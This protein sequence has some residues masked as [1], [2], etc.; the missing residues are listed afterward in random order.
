M[1]GQGNRLGYGF[2]WDQALKGRHNRCLAPSG[3]G[4]LTT[5][6]PRALPWAGMSR[7]F[8]ADRAIFTMQVIENLIKLAKDLDAATKAGKE[9]GLT[10]DEKAFYD[11]LAA[12]DSAVTAGRILTVPPL[13]R[14]ESVAQVSN[15]LCRRFPNRRCMNRPAVPEEFRPLR[16]G[17]PRHSRFGNLRYDLSA[18]APATNVCE[19]SGLRLTVVLPRCARLVPD[20]QKW[21]VR[22]RLISREGLWRR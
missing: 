8:G 13:G 16:V 7:P 21:R 12:N 10:D 6:D 9:M 3:L 4:I 20:S 2:P 14:R 1:P 15:L 17:N 22:I 5:N 19:T 11:A 18:P